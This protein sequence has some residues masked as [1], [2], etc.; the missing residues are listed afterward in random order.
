MRHI[1]LG[2]FLVTSSLFSDNS[3]ITAKEYSQELYKNPRGI[4]CYHCHGKRGEGRLIARYVHKGKARN[5][6]G[7]AINLI[8][9]KRFSKALNEGKVGMPRYFLTQKEIKSLYLHVNINLDEVEE[10][11][12]K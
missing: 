12:D 10:K 7:P 4:G 2:I 5:F 11:D 3:F 6:T 8:S 1:G 9:F